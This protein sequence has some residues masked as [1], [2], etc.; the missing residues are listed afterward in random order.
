LPLKKLMYKL[1]LFT[2][3][4][5]PYIWQTRKRANAPSTII[6]SGRTHSFVGLEESVTLKIVRQ[7]P[8][9]WC[10]I[11]ICSSNFTNT[12]SWAKEL[13]QSPSPLC[14]LR[15]AKLISPLFSLI[16]LKKSFLLMLDP[17]WTTYV[18]YPGI[19]LCWI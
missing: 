1:E 10:S 9:R 5:S 12:T 13:G 6:L 17:G 18:I 14:K 8:P 2:R 11:W 15:V 19:F 4:R 3:V 16:K 7:N